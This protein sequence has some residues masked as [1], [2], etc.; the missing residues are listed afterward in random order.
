MNN[1][2]RLP[3]VTCRADA[4]DIDVSNLIRASLESVSSHH[5]GGR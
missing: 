5:M 3:S 4:A 2:G 1:K